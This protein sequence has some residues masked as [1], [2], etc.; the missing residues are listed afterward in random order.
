MLGVVYAVDGRVLERHRRVPGDGDLD[1]RAKRAGD[2]LAVGDCPRRRHFGKVDRRVAGVGALFDCSHLVADCHRAASAARAGA[3]AVGRVFALCGRDAEGC[4]CNRYVAARSAA[5]A[6]DACRLGTTRG[7]DDAARDDDVSAG[8][9]VTAADAGAR[10][11]A[12]CIERTFA[13]DRQRTALRH[14]DAGIVRVEALDVIFAPEDYGGIALARD[15]GV[16][17]V[18]PCSIAVDIRAVE[19]HLRAG[20]DGDFDVA[21]QRPAQGST[22]GNGRILRQA[23]EIHRHECEGAV[24]D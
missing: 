24:E 15:A 14:V 4:V 5:A 7:G 20:R 1:G 16:I 21:G 18:S 8:D 12:G 17:A 22:V 9:S 11:V 23:G 2:R 6:A 3:D 19:R 13:L 10:T